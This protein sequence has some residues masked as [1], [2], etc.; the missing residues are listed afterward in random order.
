MRD[1]APAVSSKSTALSGN[2]RPSDSGATAHG[3]PNGAV[4]HMYAVVLCIG[5]LESPQHQAGGAIIRLVD[6]HH[7]EAAFQR[8]VALKIPFVFAPRGRRDGAQFAPCQRRFQQ[9]AASA[10]PA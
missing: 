5:G 3:G 9:V 2:W 6:P 10:L 8:G 7:L 1:S 4:Q